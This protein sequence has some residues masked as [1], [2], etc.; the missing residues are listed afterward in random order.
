MGV[1]AHFLSESDVDGVSVTAPDHGIGP[2][3]LATDRFAG[4]YIRP[5]SPLA[6]RRSGPTDFDL[7]SD[8][9]YPVEGGR[10]VISYDGPAT[11]RFEA[12]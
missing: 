4:M 3:Q 5:E 1:E 7:R 8:V 11:V 10:Y 6:R 12:E 9:V 2:M